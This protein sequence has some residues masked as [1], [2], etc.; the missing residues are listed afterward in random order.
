VVK[1]GMREDEVLE[2]A[3][4]EWEGLPIPLKVVMLLE[5]AAVDEDHGTL[6]IK[7]VAGA[8]NLMGGAQELDFHHLM[9]LS[10]QCILLCTAPHVSV[11]RKLSSM[12]STILTNFSM[13]T[14]KVRSSSGT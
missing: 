6:G 5:E 8:C 4:L 12:L 13:G 7:K 3:R 14:E 11:V 9:P 1:V 2:L 10:Y